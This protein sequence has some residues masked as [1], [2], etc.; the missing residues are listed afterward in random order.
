M[1]PATP[2]AVRVESTDDVE[3]V[4]CNLCGGHS[5]RELYRKPDTR[6]EVDDIEWPLV[7]CTGCGLAY[8]N[9]R[10]TASAIWRYY[11]ESYYGDRDRG[12]LGSRYDLQAAYLADLPPGRLLD[13][14]CANGD[15]LQSMA[16]RG[17]R[18]SGFEPS[19][20]SANPHALDIRSG[21][22]ASRPWPDETF[23]VITAWA[24]FE[25][26]H[27]PMT[28]FRSVA[29]L[30]KPGGRLI[31]LVTNIRSICSRYAQQEDIP[32]HLH[33][34]SERTLA[35]YAERVGLFLRRVDHDARFFGGSGRGILRM[36][37]YRTFGYSR[38]DWFQLA[39]RGWSY[40]ARRMPLLAV[41]EAVLFAVE[42]AVMSDFVICTSRL[43][44]TI[45]AVL[46]K[47]V[48]R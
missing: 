16:A 44:G 11:P 15:W 27:D 45:I 19:P 1:T 6:L 28:A 9:P 41:P 20:H 31:V 32:R 35:A 37:F 23:D 7:Q 43:N 26:L 12:R 22:L 24:V 21:D 38:N 14:G 36:W 40:R 34:F 48:S 4:A 8:V 3:T 2:R 25:H 47:P 18:A 29:R 10:P 30:L 17:W 42:R 39:K 33:V 46:D 13:V 5:T